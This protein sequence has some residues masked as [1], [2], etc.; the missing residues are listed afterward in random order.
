[1]EKIGQKYAD[2]LNYALAHDSKSLPEIIAAIPESKLAPHHIYHLSS[3]NLL[4]SKPHP[5]NA[6]QR[7][8]GVSAEGKKLLK[9]IESGACEIIQRKQSEVGKGKAKGKAKAPRKDKKTIHDIVPLA[10]EAPQPIHRNL[11]PLADGVADSVSLLL[12]QNIQYRDTMLSMAHTLA[13]FFGMKLVPLD[14][15]TP[16]NKEG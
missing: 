3:Q 9:N 16:I 14:Q 12:E 10:P 5:E 6:T 2:I 7:V 4:T 8:Y 11:S 15:P 1:M 13:K